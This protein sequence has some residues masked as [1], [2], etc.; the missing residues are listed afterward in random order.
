MFSLFKEKV[1]NP[2]SMWIWEGKKKTRDMA[3]S[4]FRETQGV[5][6][7]TQV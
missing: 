3:V 2:F 4:A 5:L 1:K 6:K 7:G